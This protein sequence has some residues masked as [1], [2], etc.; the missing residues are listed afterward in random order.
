MAVLATLVAFLVFALMAR[1]VF[2]G[3]VNAKTLAGSVADE[4]GS[5]SDLLGLGPRCRER[6]ALRWSCSV[7]DQEGSGEVAY[8]VEVE[9]DSSCWSGRLKY[10]S[11]FMPRRIDGCVPLW[12][13]SLFDLVA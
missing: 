10:Q 5:T 8:R 7:L 13:W 12:D 4:S 2:H 6:S 9:P 3:P 11:G 1:F